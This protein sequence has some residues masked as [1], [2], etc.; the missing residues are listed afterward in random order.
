M[1]V[2]EETLEIDVEALR[3]MLERDEPVTVLDIRDRESFAEWRIPGSE[4]L[5]RAAP[6]EAGAGPDCAALPDD[7]PVVV[8]CQRGNSSRK[9]ARDLRSRCGADARSLAGGMAAWSFAWNAARVPDPEGRV[10]VVQLR[11]TGKGCLSYLAGAE[12]EAVVVDPSLDP[13]VYLREA[14]GRGWTIAAVLDTHVHADHVSRARAL[15]EAAGARLLLPAQDRTRFSHEA[16]EEGDEVAVGPARLVALRVPGHT[17]ESTAYL[18]DGH[19]LFTG[20]TLFLDGVGRPD[21]E[22]GGED[23][24]RRRTRTLRGSLERLTGLGDDVLVLPGHAGGPVPF[25]GKPLA[26][27]LGEVR[28][29]VP[30][31]GADEDEFVERILERIPPT[32]PNHERIVEL[33]E[34]GALPEE[35]LVELE[36]GANRCA[37]G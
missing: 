36:A 13:E 31:L 27:P 18:L 10:G 28:D 22:G 17:G 35:G 11:R 15:A 25:D 16:L 23:E 30:L 14:A 8:V 24:L 20:D 29:A 7:R 6:A 2:R 5:E 37:A 21:L 26:A 19:F 9:V 32:P 12:G 4:P 1:T 3:T 33:N 34:A